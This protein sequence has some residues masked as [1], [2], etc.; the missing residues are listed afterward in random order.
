MLSLPTVKTH[1]RNILF[2]LG[3]RDRLQAALIL[4]GLIRKDDPLG[5]R[6]IRRLKR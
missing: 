1:V 5:E 6:S 3:V 2:K 4:R